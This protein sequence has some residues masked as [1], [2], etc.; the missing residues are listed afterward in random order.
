MNNEISHDTKKR[1][2]EAA[3]KVFSEKGKYGARMQEIADEAKINKAMLH[4]YYTNKENL[5]EKSLE[6]LFTTLF[7]RLWNFI[8]DD[9]SSLDVLVK[10]IDTYIDFL[11]ENS[12]L[13]RI[14]GREMIDGGPVLRKIFSKLLHQEKTFNPLKLVVVLEKAKKEHKIRKIDPEQTVISI[15]GMIVF[16]FM[17]RPVLNFILNVKP[18]DQK[19][20]IKARKASVIDLIIHGL[21]V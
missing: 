20:F 16:Y 18:E 14:I 7:S 11:T 8:E 3:L 21:R 19:E 2:L 5:Y 13:I 9:M 17:S 4:Y 10:F 6:F 1:I 15:L 12:G